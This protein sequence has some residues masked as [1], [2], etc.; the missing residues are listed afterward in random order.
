[1][2]EVVERQLSRSQKRHGHVDSIWSCFLPKAWP[3]ERRIWTIA[4]NIETLKLFNPQ[5]FIG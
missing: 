4:N 5:L 3:T 2:K 1:M